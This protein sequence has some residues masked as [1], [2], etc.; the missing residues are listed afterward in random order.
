M[1]AAGLMFVYARP[2]EVGGS[3]A[4]ACLQGCRA[5]K[6]S[7]HTAPRAPPRPAPP[8]CSPAHLCSQGKAAW[9]ER[10]RALL[11]RDRDRDRERRASACEAGITHRVKSTE[12]RRR[13]MRRNRVS[14]KCE[15]GEAGTAGSGTAVGFKEDARRRRFE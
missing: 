12:A 2:G 14:V 13:W 4:C 15:C 1:A 8:Q 5:G 3:V 9:Q 10:E 11:E 6:S 7:P